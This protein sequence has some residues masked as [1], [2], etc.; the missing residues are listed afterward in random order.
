[1]IAFVLLALSSMAGAA[2]SLPA[3]IK[4]DPLA[5]EDVFAKISIADLDK[6]MAP[7]RC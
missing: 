7:R 4:N 3:D 2:P 6:V 1:M 5:V